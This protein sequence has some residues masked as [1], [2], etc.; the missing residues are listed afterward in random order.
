VWTVGGFGA[1][2]VDHVHAVDDG[3]GGFTASG[4]NAPLYTANFF[5][6][7]DP[8]TDN[9]M[10]ERRLAL[11]L[12]V[13]TSTRMLSPSPVRSPSASPDNSADYGFSTSQRLVWKNSEWIK[14][15]STH[16]TYL[17]HC[18]S[19]RTDSCDRTE[20][21]PTAQEACTCHSFQIGFLPIVT[22]LC[23][24][25]LTVLDAPSLRDD[26]YCSVLAYSE[27]AKVL[28]IGLGNTVYF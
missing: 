9:N 12:D 28:A 4:S 7:S 8:V 16:R 27:A 26:F 18:F 11:A 22:H 6:N 25:L 2:S 13:D 20:N 21:P 10:H 23:S 3:R 5:G 19:E 15:G 14:E 17:T 24:P 1:S